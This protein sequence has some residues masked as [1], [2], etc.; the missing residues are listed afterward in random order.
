MGRPWAWQRSADAV[1]QEPRLVGY[2]TDLS[3]CIEGPPFGRDVSIHM[4]HCS[5]ITSPN[6]HIHPFEKNH[7]VKN[8]MSE[9]QRESLDTALFILTCCT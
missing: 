7:F 9:D 6:F 2:G 4:K 1:W 3:N 5:L 8:V